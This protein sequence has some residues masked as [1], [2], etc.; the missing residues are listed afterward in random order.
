[1]ACNRSLLKTTIQGD[2]SGCLV[3]AN[4]VQE[5]NAKRSMKVSPTHHLKIDYSYLAKIKFALSVPDRASTAS[6]RLGKAK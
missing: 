2:F 3:Y 4:D 6:D 1:M 5:S